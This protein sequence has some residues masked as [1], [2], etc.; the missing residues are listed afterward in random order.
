VKRC[1]VE[2]TFTD[3]TADGVWC[4]WSWHT[5]SVSNDDPTSLQL[6]D[7]LER[8]NFT[9]GPLNNTGAQTITLRKM[10]PIPESLGI[11][12]TE[13]SDLSV[14]GA[15]YNANPSVVSYLDVFLVDPTG[16]ITPR[17]VRVAGRLVYDVEFYNYAAPSAS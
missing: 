1:F 12:P 10:I 8:A 17:S 13:Y 3:P 14:Y 5:S 11:S 7:F 6:D 9:C 15:Q 2:L 4:G 16:N